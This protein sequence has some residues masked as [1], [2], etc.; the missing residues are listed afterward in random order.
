MAC[1]NL[2]FD[3]HILNT[4]FETKAMESQ[5]FRTFKQEILICTIYM[6]SRLWKARIAELLTK[7]F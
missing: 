7:K 1:K 3:L 4:L 6:K 2:G 5:D